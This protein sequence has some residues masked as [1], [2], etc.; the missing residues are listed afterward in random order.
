MADADA[1][2]TELRERIARLRAELRGDDVSGMAGEMSHYDQHQAD[3][4][5]ELADRESTVGVVAE[6]EERLRRLEQGLP[7]RPERY[8]PPPDDDVSTP[9][10]E[11]A[12]REQLNVIP[13]GGTRAD[14]E[15]DPQEDDDLPYMAMPGEV[16]TSEHGPAHVGR[17]DEDDD[18]LE[19]RYRP[20]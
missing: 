8:T 12:P 9:L 5:T 6:L 18:G 2:I 3:Q 19:R 1:E 10:D 15:Y 20:D 7:E 14:L 16:Y 11:P 4:G 17:T 13:V